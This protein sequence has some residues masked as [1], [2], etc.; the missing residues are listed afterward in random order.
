[1]ELQELLCKL[2][3]DDICVRKIIFPK[4]LK[5]DRETKQTWEEKFPDVKQ[6]SIIKSSNLN[7][8]IGDK[9]KV[10]NEAREK[11]LAFEKSVDI[12]PKRECWW[13]HTDFK[14]IVKHRDKDEFYL[15]G[16]LD[17]NTDND[18]EYVDKTTGEIL[19]KET[20]KNFLTV[21]KNNGSENIFVLVN[22]KDIASI[23]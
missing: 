7:I 13:V 15:M 6:D 18:V 2:V 4:W 11:H 17:T 16:F 8:I 5:K 10:L 22:I 3:G 19:E 23:N 14:N 20:F 1:M 21:E 9:Y 12:A